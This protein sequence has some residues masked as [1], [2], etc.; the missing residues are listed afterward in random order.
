[1]E[2]SVDPAVFFK[3]VIKIGL[4]LGEEFQLISL[5]SMGHRILVAK[6]VWS[7]EYGSLDFWRICKITSL[8]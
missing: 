1:M 5:Y 3:L 2:D 6:M 4:G 8:R 7:R